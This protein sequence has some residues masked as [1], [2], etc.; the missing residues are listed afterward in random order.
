MDQSNALIGQEALPEDN[1]Q[2]NPE[3]RPNNSSGSME[4]LLQ[5]EGLNLD[6]PK[7]GEIRTGVIASISDN[8]ILVSV[9]TKS[10]VITGKEKDQIPAEVET[11]AYRQR[12]PCLCDQRGSER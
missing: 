8:E 1:P 11:F 2:M 6:F 3:E 5:E 9:G 4:S 10:G 7:Q 12:D